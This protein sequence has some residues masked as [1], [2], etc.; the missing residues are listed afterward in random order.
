MAK[1]IDGKKMAEEILVEV[2]AEVSKLS[3]KPCLAVVLVGQDPASKIYVTRKS[4]ACK[5]AGIVAQD[6]RLPAE[7]SEK[8]LLELIDRLNKDAA[9]NGI[10]VQLP[11]PKH[12]NENVVTGVVA[13]G[14]DV[15]GFAPENVRKLEEG[16]EVGFGPATPLGI[17]EMLRR[18]K[19]KVKGKDAVVIGRSAIV[20][21]PVA[22]MLRNAGAHV[23]VCH[24]K[25]PN[26]ADE[27]A[28]ADILVVAVGKPKLVTG[29]MVKKG[30]IVIDVG[31]NRMENGK[32]VGDVDFD[33]ARKKASMITPVPGG[34]G[35]MTIALLLRNVVKAYRL[36]G[37]K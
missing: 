13:S 26:V 14:K 7:T 5:K 16:G 30:A 19:V 23:I 24:S 12:I 4:E 29:E 15:D 27:A 11:L 25:T 10:L 21:R 35:P 9:V 28:K 6:Y 36:Q 22:A 3:G 33:A 34:V 32:L 18:L 1:I 17:M 37:G 8:E 2:K 20:G 31:T